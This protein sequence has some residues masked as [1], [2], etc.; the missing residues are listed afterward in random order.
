MELFNVEIDKDDE[1]AVK[2]A[3]AMLIM[4]TSEIARRFNVCPT[5]LTYT[6]ADA[7]SKAE[8]E[9]KIGHG[10]LEN[11]PEEEGETIQ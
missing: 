8:E 4:A 1:E 9:G 6:L 2:R 7:I 10:T 11:E 5:C 3:L